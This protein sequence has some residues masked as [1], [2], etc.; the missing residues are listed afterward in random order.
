MIHVRP[1]DVFSLTLALHV[2]THDARPGSW[3][4]VP[5]GV[6]AALLDVADELASSGLG[7]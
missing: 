3:P 6:D 4:D 1:C 2:S 7:P 5:V